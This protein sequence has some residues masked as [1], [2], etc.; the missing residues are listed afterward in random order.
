V[1]VAIAKHV[2]QPSGNWD[3]A[4]DYSYDERNQLTGAD[5]GN[6]FTARSYGYD[7]A[8]NRTEL[9][10]QPI[11]VDPG[12]RVVDD[13]T[14]TY[15]YDEEGNLVSRTDADGNERV[16]VYDYR[17][18]LV[19][20]QDYA[21]TAMSGTL[22]QEVRYQYDTFNR[23]VA[24]WVDTN[25]NGTSDLE[26]FFVY[27]GDNVALDFVDANGATGGLSPTLAKRY[28]YGPAVDQILAQEDVT[29]SISADDRVLYMLVDHLGSVRD[30]VNN[31]GVGI[32]HYSWYD[33]GLGRWVSEDP[34]GF[35]GGDYNLVRYAGNSPTGASDPTA[36]E[37][38]AAATILRLLATGKLRDFQ[39]AM[40][41][42]AG[43]GAKG[44]ATIGAFLT[45]IYNRYPAASLRCQ[46]AAARTMQVFQ[47]AGQTAT[48]ITISLP[49]AMIFR[50][51]DGT[52]FSRS[53]EH[54]ATLSNGRVYDAVTGPNGMLLDEYI[55]YMTTVLGKVPT[56]TGIPTP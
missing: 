35:A 13:G 38:K 9:N 37:P 34:I 50:L 31:E 48:R 27:D 39:L 11:D 41:L 7:D 15:A 19:A 33:P 30:V 56:I 16:L 22:A 52:V 20:V 42:L 44:A 46:E 14:Y 28:L 3:D 10:G 40:Q 54:V 26:E 45:N 49:R 8:G 51:P 36:R 32:A 53:G 5:T 23:R 4:V 17:N 47:G 25:G 18:R 43:I 6:F 29:K 12:N 55:D 21:G 2:S 24:R 1:V